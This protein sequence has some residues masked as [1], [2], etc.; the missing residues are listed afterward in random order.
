V[1]SEGRPY[2]RSKRALERRN[3]WGAE[4]AARELGQLS[5]EDAIQLVHL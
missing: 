1:T 3:L 2:A 4:D 5:P